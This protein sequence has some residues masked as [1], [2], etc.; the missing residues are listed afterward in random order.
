[1][2]TPGEPP[3]PG[4]FLEELAEHE[5]ALDGRLQEARR[6]AREVVAGARRE[7][8]RLIEA[9]RGPLAEEAARL[10]E[11][12]LREREAA[13]RSIREETGRRIGALRLRAEANRE[14]ALGFVLAHVTG[15]EPT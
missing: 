7:S 12:A 3:E 14:R 10:R 11:E 8:E 5:R 2:K 9:A 13:I 4:E 1:M 15:R 6:R